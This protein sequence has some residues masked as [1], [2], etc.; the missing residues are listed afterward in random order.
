MDEK[1]SQ[2]IDEIATTRD[3][4]GDN[5]NDL[6]SRMRQAT[7]WRTYYERHPLMFVGA[8]LGGGFLISKAFSGGNGG[9]THAPRYESGSRTY[10]SSSRTTRGPA[11]EILDKVKG[12]LVIYGT[13]KAKEVLDKLLPGFR[14]H[15]HHL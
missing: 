7:D 5:L 6:E 13:A 1:S 10:E 8:A 4:L 11:G 9:S 2:I 15:V 3:R 12:A 14:E